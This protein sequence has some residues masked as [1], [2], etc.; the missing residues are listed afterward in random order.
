M[1]KVILVIIMLSSFIFAN[2]PTKNETVNYINKKYSNLDIFIFSVGT[3]AKL[4]IEDKETIVITYNGQ[5]NPPYG[6]NAYA[7]KFNLSDIKFSIKSYSDPIEAH[8]L[9]AI[10]KN[11][12]KCIKKSWYDAY[13]KEAYK[14]NN[15]EADIAIEQYGSTNILKVKK[16]FEHLQGIDSKKELF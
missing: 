13:A 4:K 7:Y 10:C 11:G 16:A 1:K 9:S 14:S 5:Y 12:S 6:K 3:K 15:K 8:Y 2:N